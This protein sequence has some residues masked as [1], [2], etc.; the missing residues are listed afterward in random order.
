MPTLIQRLTLALVGVIS[1]PEVPAH[2]ISEF[3]PLLREAETEMRNAKESESHIAG[4]NSTKAR[5]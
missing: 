5:N 2:Y 3:G 1:D 4:K